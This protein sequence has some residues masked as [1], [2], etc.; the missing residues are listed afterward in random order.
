M[1]HYAIKLMEVGV[2]IYKIKFVFINQNKSGTETKT[3]RPL[4]F[5]YNFF[6]FYILGF[7]ATNLQYIL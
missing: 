1:K 2:G 3:V 6:V 5:Q 7:P 4:Y